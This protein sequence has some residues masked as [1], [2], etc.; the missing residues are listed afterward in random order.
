QEQNWTGEHAVGVAVLIE[1]LVALAVHARHHALGKHEGVA[2]G[3]AQAIDPLTSAN[4]GAHRQR[5]QAGSIDLHKASV[6]FSV[7]SQ[8]GLDGEDA[9]RVVGVHDVAFFDAFI[10]GL[11]DV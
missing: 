8:H 10:F 6:G 3:M 1:D 5:L 7:R 4:A 11:H 9:A 2:G